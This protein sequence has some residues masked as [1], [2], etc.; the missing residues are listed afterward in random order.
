MTTST[1]SDLTRIATLPTTPGIGSAQRFEDRPWRWSALSDD[2]LLSLIQRVR[3]PKVG[4]RLL[5]GDVTH[6]YNGEAWVP[7]ATSVVVELP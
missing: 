7:V 2:A 1:S 4:D 5:L 3:A 6:E